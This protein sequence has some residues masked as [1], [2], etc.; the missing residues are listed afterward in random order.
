MD[1]KPK[2]PGFWTA[3]FRACREGWRVIFIGLILAF[4]HKLW[5][6]ACHGPYKE[7]FNAASVPAFVILP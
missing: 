2:E 4:I 7:F 1:E 6:D 3:L 5:E